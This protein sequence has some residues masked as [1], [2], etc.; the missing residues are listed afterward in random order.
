[1]KYTALSWQDIAYLPDELQNSMWDIDIQQV[2]NGDGH[3]ILGKSECKA[4]LERFVEQH[5]K[6]TTFVPTFLSIEEKRKFVEQFCHFILKGGCD[7]DLL[8]A[9]MDVIR[10]F[11]REDVALE[12][13]HKC[14]QVNGVSFLSHVEIFMA[15]RCGSFQ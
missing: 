7:S 15:S 11:C 12:E 14:H 4:R 10:M 1:L 6:E 8:I 13:L 9:M 2:L 5:D 3:N